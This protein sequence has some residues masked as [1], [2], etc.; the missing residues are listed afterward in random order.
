MQCTAQQQQQQQQQNNK[1]LKLK[2]G[3]KN[4]QTVRTIMEV[5]LRAQE[6][7]Q[8]K[9]CS[10]MLENS[11][12]QQ[13]VG[14]REDEGGG[15]ERKLWQHV[16]A[17]CCMNCCCCCTH[18]C[19]MRWSCPH[20]PEQTPSLSPFPMCPVPPSCPFN[21]SCCAFVAL[22]FCFSCCCCCWC[23]SW[24]SKW[25]QKSANCTIK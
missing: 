5:A 23:C 13:C 1:K 6:K 21:K 25:K 19:T 4:C 15:E 16:C 12:W 18:V 24:H 8:E 14:G 20:L 22:H 7:L 9:R 3:K 17:A 10:Q 2:T 11:M